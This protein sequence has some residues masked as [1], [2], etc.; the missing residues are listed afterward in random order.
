MSLLLFLSQYYLY[1]FY[2][3]NNKFA[4]FIMMGIF[5]WQQLDL[6]FNSDILILIL[7][8][9]ISINNFSM[10]FLMWFNIL[11]ISTYTPNSF[12]QRLILINL[13]SSSFS[14]AFYLSVSLSIFLSLW[15]FSSISIANLCLENTNQFCSLKWNVVIIFLHLQILS[16]FLI[17][18]IV[19]CYY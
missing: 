19:F 14:I 2:N 15:P 17:V 13:R 12:P 16:L 1:V 3:L 5:F 9:I 8:K 4:Y 11:P 10:W 18:L 7:Y 6:K